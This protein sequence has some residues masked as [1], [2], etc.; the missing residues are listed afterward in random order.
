MRL[1]CPREQYLVLWQREKIVVANV[2]PPL[3]LMLTLSYASHMNFTEFFKGKKITV[4]G[5]GLL[6]RGV[7]DTALLAECGADII[8]TDLKSETELQAS[9]DKL[10]D[11]PNIKYTLGEHKEED[12]EGRDMVL[13]SAGV[14]KDSV[15][16]EHVRQQNIHLPAN[17]QTRLVQSAAL[18]AELSQ[19]PMLAVTGTRGKST[20]TAM[21]HHVLETVTGE[22][23]IKGGN[24]RGVSNLQ[25]LKDVKEH[26]L[27]VFELDSWQLQGFGWSK[28]SPPVAVFTNFMD[29]HANYYKGDMD[30]YFADKANIF[31][32]QEESDVLVTT[33]EVFELIKKFAIGKNITLG[34]EVVLVDSSVIPDD[35]ILTMPGEHNRLNT[36]LAVS[37]CKAVGLTEDEIF[38]AL[39]S[40]PG[41]EGRL[42]LLGTHNGAK[43][44][45]DN[46][47]TTPQATEAGL[48]A[49]GGDNN[50]V[51]IVGGTDK[52]IELGGLPQAIAQHC[53]H[54]VLYGGTGTE[55]LKTVLPGSVTREEHDNLEEA[56]KAALAS[57]VPGNVILFS[58]GFASFGA[59]FRNEYDRND[60]FVAAVVRLL[61]TVSHPDPV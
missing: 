59:K 3:F 32:Y 28:I 17:R 27:A 19:V 10:K 4:M 53:A 46:N 54:V 2:W 58:P 6:G 43:I 1:A 36:S 7:G 50:V 22:S 21:I 31:L 61:D 13:V 56:V 47:A 51:L 18:F 42:Q 40:F 23:I 5:L 39:A 60:K 49:V 14:P 35:A 11:F 16:L 45:N 25:L 20:V 8:V 29:D 52:G 41:V 26:S 15:Y 37:A 33:P 24:I 48:E 30:V 9:L 12:F 55:K 44:Y 34:Q 38:E 57:T